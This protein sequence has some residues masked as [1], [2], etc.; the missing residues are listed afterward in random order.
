MFGAE[1]S[2]YREL[3]VIAKVINSITSSADSSGA[4]SGA[5]PGG[6]WARGAI[7]AGGHGG[8]VPGA[9]CR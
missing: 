1:I 6:Q 5:I 7:G 2:T 4:G 9:G 3:K 8:R